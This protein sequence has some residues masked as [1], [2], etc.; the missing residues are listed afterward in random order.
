MVLGRGPK[1]NV[2]TGQHWN[3]LGYLSS[4]GRTA[5]GSRTDPLG[6]LDFIRALALD[7]KWALQV[8]VTAPVKSTAQST[9]TP[10]TS[11]AC[12]VI[13]D[14]DWMHLTYNNK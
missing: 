9:R 5:S 4:M 10:R 14:Y 8:L 6:G 12:A 2:E 7:Q 13:M 3:R 11:E 1:V